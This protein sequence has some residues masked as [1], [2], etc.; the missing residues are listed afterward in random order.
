MTYFIWFYRGVL[1]KINGRQ[2]QIVLVKHKGTIFYIPFYKNKMVYY[3]VFLNL[4]FV[5]HIEILTLEKL[6]LSKTPLPINFKLKTV[7]ELI[8][9]KLMADSGLE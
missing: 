5:F 6:A 8:T 1:T 7:F 4:C 3:N 2:Q 9:G